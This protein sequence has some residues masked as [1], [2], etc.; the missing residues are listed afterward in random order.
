MNNWKTALSRAF[1]P[2]PPLK[3][4][5][6]LMELPPPAMPPHRFLI[7]QIGYIR[8]WVWCVSA[9]VFLSALYSAHFLPRDAIWITAACTPLLALS[10][11]AESGRSQFYGMEE[12][13]MAT[14]F[15]FKSVT[16]ARLGILGLMDLGLLI[17]LIPLGVH[18]APLSA[19]VCIVTPY[20][21]TCF[22]GLWILRHFKGREAMYACGGVTLCVSF[23]VTLSHSQLPFLY[24]ENCLA[25]WAAAAI[26]L[27]VSAGKQYKAFI[28]EQEEFSWS[29]S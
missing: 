5:S 18:A 26:V 24:Q 23:S 20:L 17:L 7:T 12:L 2:P 25:W 19:G 14:R 21:G 22:A 8:K 1:A 10:L 28:Q 29:L 4:A 9:L 11:I 15:S 3:K 6:F 27:C 16:L 13:E